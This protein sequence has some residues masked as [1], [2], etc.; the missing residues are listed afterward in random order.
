MSATSCAWAVSKSISG[1]GSEQAYKEKLFIP[2]G[3]HDPKLQAHVH[4]H[5]HHLDMHEWPLRCARVYGPAKPAL[6]NAAGIL[7]I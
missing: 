7:S 3:G 4:T 2:L 6:L 5:V 1:R